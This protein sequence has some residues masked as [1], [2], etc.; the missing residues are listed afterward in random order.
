MECSKQTEGFNEGVSGPINHHIYYFYFSNYS[1]S[2]PL[3]FIPTALLSSRNKYL[4]LGCQYILQLVVGM[5]FLNTYLITSF[6]LT[7]LFKNQVFVQE[8]MN[9]EGALRI[10]PCLL[11][12]SRSLVGLHFSPQT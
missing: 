9:E 3:S 7:L 2:F 5:I 10:G 6:P 4:T 1:Q 12:Q 8:M 11:L